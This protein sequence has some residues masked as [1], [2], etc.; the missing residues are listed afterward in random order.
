MKLQV[1]TLNDIDQILSLHSKYQIDTI[2]PKDKIDGFITTSFTKKQLEELIKEEQGAFIA[3]QNDKVVGYVMSASWQ[4]WSKWDIYVYMASE[5]PNIKYKNTHLTATNSYQYGPVCIDKN[6][7]GSGVFEKLFYFALSRM[8]KRYKFLVTF[9]NKINTRSYEA[10]TRKIGLDVVCEF[11]FNNN[12][13]YELVC[14]TCKK[15]AI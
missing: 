2:E 9:I 3:I 14:D 4:Y 1:A 5:L 6:V 10:H 15:V 8:E 7:R 12:H 13:Y 11:E